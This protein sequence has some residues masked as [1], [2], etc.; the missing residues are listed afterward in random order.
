MTTFKKDVTYTDEVTYE[1]RD[2]CVAVSLLTHDAPK[3]IDRLYKYKSRK[4]M[5]SGTLTEVPDQS[6]F[7]QYLH[8]R[9][10]EN[11]QKFLASEFLFRSFKEAVLYNSNTNPQYGTIQGAGDEGGDFIFVKR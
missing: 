5:T 4:A 9:L 6:V 11:D 3:A 8:K 10:V 7:I 2:K 1:L